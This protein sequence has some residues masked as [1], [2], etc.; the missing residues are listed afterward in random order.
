M[1]D[2]FGR[3][4]ND[5][6]A[7]FPIFSIDSSYLESVKPF[8][9]RA[10]AERKEVLLALDFDD[11]MIKVQETNAKK[12]PVINESLIHFLVNLF[13]QHQAAQFKIM[14][15]SARVPDLEI[16]DKVHPSLLIRSAL[17]VFLNLLNAELEEK[18]LHDKKVM[19]IDDQ[20][21]FCIRGEEGF[22]KRT[23]SYSNEEDLVSFT[24]YY[25]RRSHRHTSVEELHRFLI[26]GR[27]SQDIRFIHKDEFFLEKGPFLAN[28]LREMGASYCLH[29]DDNLEQ[30]ESVYKHAKDLVMPVIVSSRP[31]PHFHSSE[32]IVA[33]PARKENEE[34]DFDEWSYYNSIK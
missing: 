7:R 11:T 9:L 28:L 13:A 10:I 25:W 29:V 14:I 27:L 15:V 31:H 18:S 33:P 16:G 21:I 3:P 23:Y 24:A 17:P 8:I 19:S 20:H 4:G 26:A 5:V 1:R 22:V 30:I 2:F 6:Q 32:V 34:S 12:I